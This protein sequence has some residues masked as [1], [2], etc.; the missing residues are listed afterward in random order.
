MKNL[1][2]KDNDTQL[3]IQL[4][5]SQILLLLER[6]N[7]ISASTSGLEERRDNRQKAIKILMDILEMDKGDVEE[8]YYQ[9]L[10][11]T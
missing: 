3:V 9:Y 1:D 10:K 7:H 2:W 4:A 11:N 8:I 5:L 6:N